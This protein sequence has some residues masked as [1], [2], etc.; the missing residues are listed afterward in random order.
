[1]KFLRGSPFI[2]MY[3]RQV[4]LSMMAARRV[5]INRC[6]ADRLSMVA[7][8]GLETAKRITV[9][10]RRK[11]RFNNIDEVSNVRGIAPKDLE[12]RSPK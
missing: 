5:D 7:G 12:V 6:T 3:R 1:M 2:L 8:V 11:Q 10:R 4:V 9:Y